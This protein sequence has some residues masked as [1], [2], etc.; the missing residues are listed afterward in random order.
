MSEVLIPIG[1]GG[2]TSSDELTATKDKI[3][4]G[5]TA[6][7]KDSDDEAIAGTMPDNSTCT[8]NGSVPGINS[9]YPDVPTREGN[10]L[11]Y[12]TDTKGV[13]R[14]NLEPPRGFY[15]GGGGSYINRP[16][17]D[18]GNATPAQVLSGATFTSENGLKISGSII[19][20]GQYQ[21]G[22]VGAGNDYIAIN[23]LPEGYYRSNGANWAPEARA[24]ASD[25]GNAAAFQ[26]LSGR[27]FTSSSG[28]NVS[29]TMPSYTGNTN[30]KTIT[31][32][33]AQQTWKI[34]AGYHDGNGYVIAQR[35]ADGSAPMIWGRYASPW[36]DA[37][38]VERDAYPNTD[39]VG[40][41]A[42]GTNGFRIQYPGTYRICA[43]VYAGYKNKGNITVKKG[44][45]VIGTA[46]PSNG[47]SH[48]ECSVGC[49]VNDI[50]YI[51]FTAGFM[52][53]VT[54]FFEG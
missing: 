31:P 21:Y 1:G 9:S 37:A 36:T 18:F 53:W 38:N 3:L 13:K 6:V 51:H 34:P 35:I 27:T 50:I 2:G 12:H 19:D 46:T 47:N 22:G 11:Q 29:G 25:F 8:S 7:T 23:G 33:N 16:A 44:E 4:Y 49:N 14:I 43:H 30:R 20:R 42:N 5:Y 15:P 48:V 39:A 54:V 28:L 52:Q 45:T 17:S 40:L 41:S 26:V 24:K 32:S 10:S